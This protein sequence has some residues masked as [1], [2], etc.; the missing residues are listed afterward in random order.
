MNHK[1]IRGFALSPATTGSHDDPP[2]RQVPYSGEIGSVV[3]YS[4]V[5]VLASFQ[6]GHYSLICGQS[7]FV[8]AFICEYLYAKGKM[9]DD[10]AVSEGTQAE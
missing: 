5:K 3:A 10:E 8:K 1:G 6:T 4:C 7:I 9:C 2:E